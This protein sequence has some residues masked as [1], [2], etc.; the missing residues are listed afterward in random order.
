MAPLALELLN[1]LAYISPKLIILHVWGKDRWIS[2]EDRDYGYSQRHP[3]SFYDGGRYLDPQLAVDRAHQMV[4]E[5]AD[6]I[7]IGGQSSRPGS[8]PVSEAEEA[9]RVLPS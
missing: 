5:G 1:Q 8:E 6:I 7:D 4:A 2:R 3:D 9:D